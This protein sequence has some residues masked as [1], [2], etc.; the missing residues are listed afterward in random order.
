MQYAGISYRQ[1]AKLASSQEI[2]KKELRGEVERP[3]SFCSKRKLVQA[4]K[5]FSSGPFLEASPSKTYFCSDSA[6]PAHKNVLSLASSRTLNNSPEVS[7]EGIPW[8]RSCKIDN[9]H[10]HWLFLLKGYR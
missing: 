6:V 1:H 9:E 2:D 4:T 10:H 8:M 5:F 7:L 3:T